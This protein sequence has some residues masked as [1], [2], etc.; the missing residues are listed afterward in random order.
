MVPINMKFLMVL[1]VK[2]KFNLS[3]FEMSHQFYIFNCLSQGHSLKI[4]TQNAVDS[5][6]MDIIKLLNS[7][8]FSHVLQNSVDNPIMSAVFPKTLITFPS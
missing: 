3:F 1:E 2:L 5:L 4:S 7:K 6:Y 8:K